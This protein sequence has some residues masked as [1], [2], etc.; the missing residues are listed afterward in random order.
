[1]IVVHQA[2]RAA[3][4]AASPTVPVPNTGDARPGRRPHGV[5][6]GA[7]AGL[8]AAAERGDDL[9]RHGRVQLDHVSL[10]RHGVGGEARLA[11]EVRVDRAAGTSKG[12]RSI[13]SGG[14]EVAPPEVMADPGAT[15]RAGGTRPAGAKAHRHAVADPHLRHRRA[16]RLDHARTLVAE[17][18][19]QRHRVPLVADDQVGVADPAGR[20]PHQQLVAAQLVD[21]ELLDRERRSL[22]LGDGGLD[23]HRQPCSSARHRV[24]SQPRPELEQR[25]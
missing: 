24:A 23:T 8:D 22:G 15:G 14:P 6:H 18:R 16:H 4:T 21:L 1:M 9:K 13:R 17:H 19:G 11:E 20:H 5:E 12:G 2:T 10:C 25:R 3:I 7:G